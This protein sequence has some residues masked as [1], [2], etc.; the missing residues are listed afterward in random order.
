[1]GATT[2]ANQEAAT[3]LVGALEKESAKNQSKILD[4]LKNLEAAITKHDGTMLNLYMER[5]EDTSGLLS[6]TIRD[7]T[8]ALAAIGELRKDKEFMETK[9][10][11]V[12][13]LT[14]RVDTVKKLLSA[15]LVKLKEL[16]KKALTEREALSGGKEEAVEKYA[17]LEDRVNDKKKLIEK[18]YDDLKAL[19]VAADKAVTA[20]NQAGLTSARTKIIDLK[21]SSEKGALSGLDK[22]LAAFIQKYKSAG[23]NTDAT[24]LKDE[25]YT[26]SSLVEEGEKQFKRLMALGQISAAPKAPPATSKPA[27][28]LGS[29][30]IA[31]AAK[32]LGIDSKDKDKLGKLLNGFPRDKWATELAKLAKEL[33]LKSTDGKAMVVQ[34]NMVSGIQRSSL[35][36]I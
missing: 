29:D 20:K 1:M 21:L 15:Q 35:I 33:K 7:C 2:K 19:V 17:D 3:K 16:D 18:K 10:A 9:F 22:E 23:L 26:L 11:V 5:V 27:P 32:Q 31:K 34:L 25:V 24:L 14:S 4:V 28:K 13:D 36:D 8:P 30:D 6:D 12:K